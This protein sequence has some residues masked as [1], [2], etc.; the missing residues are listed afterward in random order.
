MNYAYVE[1]L[2]PPVTIRVDGCLICEGPVPDSRV[3]LLP[4]GKHTRFRY[5]LCCS[6]IRQFRVI[7]KRSL[8]AYRQQILSRLLLVNEEMSGALRAGQYLH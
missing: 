8:D 3:F 4:F 2:G 7:N 6:C 1:H 5:S